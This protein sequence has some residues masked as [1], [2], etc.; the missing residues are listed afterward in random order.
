[1]KHVLQF[2]SLELSFS[3]KK[4]LSGVYMK[5]E[6]GEIVGLLGRNGS[7]KSSLMKIVF[8]SLDAGYRHVRIN[9]KPVNGFSRDIAYLPQHDLIPSY[10]TVGRAFSL[11]RIDTRPLF[12]FFP[13]L[14]ELMNFSPGNLSGGSLRLIETLLILKS[15]AKFCILDEPF[16]GVMPVHV[17]ALID[18]M[19]IEKQHKGIIIT[20]HM[21][22]HVSAV[23]DRLYLLSNG[24]TYA[25][26]DSTQLMTMG[27][28][29][30]N[31]E[32]PPSQSL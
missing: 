27:Y 25:V 13:Q 12:E 31:E 17:E 4:V 29:P 9:D 3:D 6:T 2:D 26:H 21:Y 10:I 30:M 11:F 7:G 16:S 32:H 8:G 20:D 24:T 18:L 14:R 19:K 28:V 22:R 15:G 23:A 1:M 5:C